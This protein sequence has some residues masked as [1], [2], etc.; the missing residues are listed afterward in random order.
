MSFEPIPFKNVNKISYAFLTILV[1]S[2]EMQ[3]DKIQVEMRFKNTA[4]NNMSL[5]ESENSGIFNI[6]HFLE[7]LVSAN[8]SQHFIKKDW[9]LIELIVQFGR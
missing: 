6:H 4:S 9:K 8:I 2:K 5:V 7:N 3:F 1:Y